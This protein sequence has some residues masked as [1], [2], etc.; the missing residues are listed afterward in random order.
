MISPIAVGPSPHSSGISNQKNQQDEFRDRSQSAMR[1]PI[2]Q[3]LADGKPRPAHIVR[4]VD[5]AKAD[6]DIVRAA[7]GLEAVFV[8]YMMQAM[9]KT[10]PDNEFDLESPA[11][12]MY[13]AE[14]DSKT[15]EKAAKGG[16]LGI[17]DMIIDYLQTQ[18]YNQGVG[19]RILPKTEKT[20]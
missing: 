8:D 4:K 13:Q 17:G 1:I 9:R 10:V 16:G 5:R 7:E 11:S 3:S 2:D 14:L 20:R 15:A 19:Q 18:R 6:P 12:K